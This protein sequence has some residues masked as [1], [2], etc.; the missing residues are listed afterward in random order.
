[1][2]RVRAMS[3][4]C[5]SGSLPAAHHCCRETRDARRRD[6][7]SHIANV[8]QAG[9]HA[10]RDEKRPPS[11]GEGSRFVS[12]RGGTRTRTAVRPGVFETPAATGYATRARCRNVVPYGAT[13]NARG[14][15]A[16]ARV[17]SPSAIWRGPS[18]L[19][20]R[21]RDAAIASAPAHVVHLTADLVLHRKVFG[22]LDRAHERR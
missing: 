17:A 2:S 19:P 8:A 12:A 13:L 4:N 7:I 16:A 3:A 6:E 14:N 20:T 10:T 15:S 5:A 22:A 1:M 11:M 21:G 18:P 9:S